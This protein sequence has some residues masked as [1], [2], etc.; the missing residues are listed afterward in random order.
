MLYSTIGVSASHNRVDDNDFYGIGRYD[1]QDS[2]LAGNRT[3]GNGYDGFIVEASSG[4]DVRRHRSDDNIADGIRVT[5]GS[6]G[7]LLERN[8][9]RGNGEHDAHDDDRPANTWTGN[10]CDTDFPAGTICE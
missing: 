9:M 2:S 7:N 6:S 4:N 8:R 5:G 10:R 3:D 1:A